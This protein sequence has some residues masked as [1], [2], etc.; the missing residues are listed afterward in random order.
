L[1]EN[2]KHAK[3]PAALEAPPQNSHHAFEKQKRVEERSFL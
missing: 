1:A 3:L 2:G